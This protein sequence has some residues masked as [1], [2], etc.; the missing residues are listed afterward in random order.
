MTIRTGSRW[1][2]HRRLRARQSGDARL[3]QRHVSYLTKFI[4]KTH[5]AEEAA[6]LRI[7]DRL[8][9]ARNE[10]KRVNASAYLD[11]LRGTIGATPLPQP[12]R[13]GQV[14]FSM[15]TTTTMVQPQ[16]EVSAPAP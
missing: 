5:Y 9:K 11:E 3:W 6:R 4:T 12:A 1:S 15:T 13:R 2:N 14:E 10:L 7:E 16:R 8:H